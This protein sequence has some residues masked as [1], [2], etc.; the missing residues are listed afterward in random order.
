[1]PISSNKFE[2]QLPFINLLWSRLSNEAGN[3]QLTNILSAAMIDKN[4]NPIVEQPYLFY[5]VGS[6]S[7]TSF[8]IGT[9]A[10]F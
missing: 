2:I 6:E 9:R 10:R 5:Y 1:V 8:P 4:L 7:I 3:D